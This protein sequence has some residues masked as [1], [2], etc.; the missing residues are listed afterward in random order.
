MFG[1]SLTF[2]NSGVE[3][4][5]LVVFDRKSDYKCLVLYYNNFLYLT[6]NTFYD[7]ILRPPPG[8]SYRVWLNTIFEIFAD[9]F[10]L[11][12]AARNLM[13]DKTFWLYEAKRYEVTGTCPTLDDLYHLVKN[14]KYPLLSREARYQESAINRLR[15][16]LNVFGDGLCSNRE[17]KWEVLLNTDFA[18]GTDGIPTDYQSFFISYFTAKILLYRMTNGPRES[19]LQN[20]IVIDEASTVFK[21]HRG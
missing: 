8:I 6:L 17:L 19:R 13:L 12:V 18:I 2:A 5:M 21:E 9:Y 16:I 11:R 10:D 3:K 1:T 15:G 7:N 14:T 4:T 20:L